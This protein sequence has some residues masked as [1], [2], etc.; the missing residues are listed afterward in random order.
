MLRS[1]AIADS[2]NAAIGRESDS[3]G[4]KRLGGYFGFLRAMP[5]KEN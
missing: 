1:V 3:E 2:H 4:T 5:W